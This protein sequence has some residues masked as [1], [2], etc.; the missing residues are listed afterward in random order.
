MLVT[1]LTPHI[2]YDRAAKIAKHAHINNTSLREAATTLGEVSEEQ[3]D[4]W[5]NAHKMVGKTLD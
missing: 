3:F 2:G 1:A 4:A 5:V